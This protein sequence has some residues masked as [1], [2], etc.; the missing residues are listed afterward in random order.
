MKR[1][2]YLKTAL[3]GAFLFSIILLASGGHSQEAREAGTLPQDVRQQEGALRNQ[4]YFGEFTVKGSWVLDQRGLSLARAGKETGEFSIDQIDS[5][6]FYVYSGQLGVTQ[7]GVSAGGALNFKYFTGFSY[8]YLQENLPGK[9]ISFDVMIPENMVSPSETVPNRMRISLKSLSAGEWVNYFGEEEWTKIKEPGN[10]N[11][12]L[13]IP[14]GPVETSTKQIFRPEGSIL[15]SIEFF[16]MEGAKYHPVISFPFF[17]FNVEGIDFDPRVFK[18]QLM[19]NGYVTE[20]EYLPAFGEGSTFISAMGK[21]ID[22]EFGIS[23]MQTALAGSLS[24]SDEDVYLALSV[25]IPEELRH[26]KGTLALTIKNRKGTVRSSVKNFDS[27]NLEGKVFLTLPLDVFLADENI[28]DVIRN[29]KTTIRIKTNKAHTAEMMPIILEPLKVKQGRLIAF[30]RK[31]EVRDVQD[32]GGYEKLEI[33]K[34]GTLG[35]SG[36]SVRDLSKGL[37]QMDATIRLKGGIDWEGPYYRVELMRPFDRGPADLDNMRLEVLISPL[38]DTTDVWQ[39]PYRARIGLLDENGNIM[40]GPNVSLS[41]GLSS[42]A[43]LEVSLTHPIPKGI[44]THGFDPT[45][46]KA[47]IINIEASHAPSEVREIQLS[48]VNL[49]ITPKEYVR[50]S[51]YKMIDFGRFERDPEKWELMRIL[52]ESGGYFVGVNY[53]FPVVDV[54]KTILQVPQVYPCVGMKPTDPMHFGFSSDVTRKATE[55]AF[56]DFIDNQVT[57]ARILVLGHLEGVFTWNE[58][59]VDISGFE[60]LEQEVQKAAGMS[61]EKLVEYLEENEDTFIPRNDKGRIPGIEEHVI[62][63]FKALLDILE[64]I[65]QETGKRLMV[66][67]SMYDFML[68]DGIREEGPMR[69][70]TVGEHPEV[71]TDPLVKVKAHALFWK[72][73]KIFSSD[74]RFYKY[75]AV[76]EIMNEPA[77]ASDLATTKNFADLVNFCGEGLYI[78]KSVIGPKIPVTVGFRSWAAD[79][80]YWS[81]IAEGIDLLMIHYWESLES[82]NIDNPG[83][84]SLDMPVN[85]LWRYLGTEANGRPATMAEISPGGTFKKNLFRL[86]RAGYDFSL[87]WSYSGHDGHDVKPVIDQLAEYQVANYKFAAL[88]KTPYE[89]LKKAFLYIL[90]ARTVY[91]GQMRMEGKSTQNDPEEVGFSS[92]LTDRIRNISDDELRN[93]IEEIMVIAMLKG[94]PLNY[95]NIKFIMFQAMG[96]KGKAGSR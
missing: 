96:K 62:D 43:Y 85:E 34:D 50:M 92:Y 14:E 93:I 23:E 81:T 27:S 18:W 54:P 65:E 39:K 71:V 16:A 70:F 11:F 84:W 15:F 17:D 80:Q 20:G 5:R 86:E 29:L 36:I 52:K 60:G 30:D 12:K 40:F 63:D 42:L 79:L 66:A 90:T 3:C 28:E 41:E 35:T 94:A 74:P 19:K 59:G 68:G 4:A 25:F 32:L 87:A 37:Y 46:A 2:A 51:P 58:T 91:D 72:I 7:G 48:F 78:M 89:R 49:S 9:T 56:R 26:Q 13:K 61:V 10:Y 73:M 88:E 47:I 57:V 55:E 31:W 1:R 75:V 6:V 24:G 22:M 76:M 69:I 95:R 38:T 44:V 82:Y 33:R 21:G 77:N 8:A 67:L 83:L 45:K 53:P 64:G